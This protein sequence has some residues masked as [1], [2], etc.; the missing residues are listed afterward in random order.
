MRHSAFVEHRLPPA[1]SFA[2]LPDGSL[3]KLGP[4]PRGLIVA[5]EP[6]DLPD[7]APVWPACSVRARLR[8][9]SHPT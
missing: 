7:N 8:E 2:T 4:V 9:P 1:G 6:Q 5:R 3:G